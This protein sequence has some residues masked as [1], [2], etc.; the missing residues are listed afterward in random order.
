LKF[1]KVLNTNGSIFFKIKLIIEII[2][3]WY[4]E[5]N[6]IYKEAQITLDIYNEHKK[7]QKMNPEL[8][9]ERSDHRNILIATIILHYYTF[10][11]F[12]LICIMMMY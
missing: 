3:L 12:I 4:S 5:L 2:K 1:K 6:K 7:L 8:Y 11:S 9:P 10:S